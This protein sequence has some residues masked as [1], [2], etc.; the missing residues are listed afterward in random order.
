M[1]SN[2][3]DV[4]GVV[5]DMHMPWLSPEIQAIVLLLVAARGLFIS[6]DQFALSVGARNRHQLA[7]WLR[8]AGLPPLQKLAGWIRVM[9]W[10]VEYEENGTTVCG[11]CLDQARDPAYPYR[12]V[13]NITGQL[14]STVRMLG[15]VWVLEE[16]LKKC[17]R[18]QSRLS[19][20]G[21]ASVRQG[22]RPRVMRPA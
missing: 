4:V 1:K 22:V 18:R 20:A 15:L 2:V 9:V 6:A 11:S 10:V 14:W 5:L 3:T 19:A 13:K 7:Y 8:R 21:Q 16:F 17:R 12:L